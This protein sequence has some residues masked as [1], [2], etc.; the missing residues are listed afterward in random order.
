MSQRKQVQI[1]EEVVQ[2]DECHKFL[3]FIMP[4]DNQYTFV[5]ENFKISDE[6][7]QFDTTHFDAT[8]RLNLDNKEVVDR[9]LVEFM[10]RSKCTYRVTKTTHPAMKRVLL[11]YTYHCQHYRKPLSQKQILAHLLVKRS[12]KKFPHVW[13]TRQK[14][15]CPSQLFVKILVSMK[16]QLQLAKNILL[17]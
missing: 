6:I 4:C 3:K 8:F 7:S 12:S 14:T 1:V 15:N 11:K 13:V 9:W 17:C 16:K 10:E 2:L 5:V